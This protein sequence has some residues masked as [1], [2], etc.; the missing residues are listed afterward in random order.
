MSKIMDM[1]SD[2][3]KDPKL[4]NSNIY[5]HLKLKYFDKI[6][7]NLLVTNDFSITIKPVMV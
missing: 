6:E 3:M 7:K 2:L 1:V 5:S 4:L